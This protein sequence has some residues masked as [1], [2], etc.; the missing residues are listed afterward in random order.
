[1]SSHL[2]RL[3][4]LLMASPSLLLLGCAS[5]QEG[6][7]RTRSYLGWH[8]VQERLLDSEDQVPVV[9]R[10]RTLGLRL[11]PGLGI[12]YFDDSRVELP[13]GCR[14]VIFV[15]DLKQLAQFSEAYPS[16]KAEMKP[17]VKPFDQ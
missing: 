2:L 10:T 8:T 1:M 6:G 3:C 14:L 9:E 17:C 11:G 4:V 12:G 15:K 5:K 13:P 16:L 7:Y